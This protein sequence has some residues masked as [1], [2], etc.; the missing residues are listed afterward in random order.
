[1]VSLVALAVGLLLGALGVWL[2]REREMRYLREELKIAQ[3]RLLH[4][5]RDEKAIIPPRPTVIEPPKPL[6]PELMEMVA[7]WE[8]PEA[9]ATQEAK[10]RSLYFERGWGVQAILRAAEDEHPA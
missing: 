9:Q 8:S 6:P 10:L 2:L 4:A 7:E 5:W 1:M 3:D